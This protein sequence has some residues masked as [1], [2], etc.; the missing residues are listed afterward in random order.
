MI[1]MLV[2]E[3]CRPTCRMFTT[4][5]HSGRRNDAG[6]IVPQ[7]DCL[8]RRVARDSIT[9]VHM[10]ATFL[11]GFSKPWLRC[12]GS[13]ISWWGSV[14]RSQALAWWWPYALSVCTSGLRKCWYTQ[15][16]VL[17][18]LSIKWPIPIKS[19]FAGVWS[20]RNILWISSIALDALTCCLISWVDR[21]MNHHRGVSCFKLGV[22]AL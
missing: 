2:W 4:W 1:L 18:S 19:Y 16:T 12:F 7:Q 15:I 11:D 5:T 9:N 8:P 3:L 6:V 10:R 14:R 20:Y 21:R 13:S 17:F 22:V